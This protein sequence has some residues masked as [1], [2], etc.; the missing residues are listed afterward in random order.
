MIKLIVAVRRHPDLSV[1]AFQ[2]HWRIEHARLVRECPATRRYVR[3]YVQCHTLA[4]EY[5]AGAVA[6][7]GTAELWFDTLADKDAFFADPDYL[8]DVR[9][10]EARFADMAETVFFVTEEVPVLDGPA[11]PRPCGPAAS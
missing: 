2:R 10:D 7:D 8:R 3:R 5:G 11:S 9:P 4:S 6:F 1:E